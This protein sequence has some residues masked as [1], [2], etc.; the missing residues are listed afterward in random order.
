M[1]EFIQLEVDVINGEVQ[2]FPV[3][4]TFRTDYLKPVGQ[5]I[6]RYFNEDM[7]SVAK[8][9]FMMS[10]GLETFGT[11]ELKTTNDFWQ[12]VYESNTRYALMNGCNVLID[13]MCVIL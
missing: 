6:V 9:T 11:S 8:R 7:C 13:D 3:I 12:F 2:E 5:T 4:M 10:Y 1:G